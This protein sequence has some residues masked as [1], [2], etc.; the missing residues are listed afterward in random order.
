MRSYPTARHVEMLDMSLLPTD[1]AAC[2]DVTDDQLPTMRPRRRAYKA[3]KAELQRIYA[4]DATM[5]YSD[6]LALGEEPP[7]SDAEALRSLKSSRYRAK[8]RI[9]DRCLM[10]GAK[11][12][13]TLTTRDAVGEAD[14]WRLVVEFTKRIGKELPGASFVAVP[15]PN[16]RGGAHC[17]LPTNRFIPASL[18]RRIWH[19]VLTGT[20]GTKYGQASPGNVDLQYKAHGSAASMADYVAKRLSSYISKDI[21]A[22]CESTQRSKGRKRYR[23]LG[24][25]IPPTPETTFY[26]SAQVDL[27]LLFGQLTDQAAKPQ[28]IELSS[29]Y[30]AV[31][32]RTKKPVNPV[33]Y[34]GEPLS[35]RRPI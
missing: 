26:V 13:L 11:V 32:Y 24:A 5:S 34:G 18:A 21:K 25:K 28:H 31:I 2:H 9:H 1:L 17:H 20:P 23:C 22:E 29:G 35:G 10:M 15:E 19:E 14:L 8:A 6:W 33:L 7:E 16:Q 27:G 4:S 3:S 30:V 12:L